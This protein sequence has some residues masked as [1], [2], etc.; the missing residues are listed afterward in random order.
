MLL[1]KDFLVLTKKCFGMQLGSSLDEIVM[2]LSLFTQN[3]KSP[4]KLTIKLKS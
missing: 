2:I 1:P 4:T 3:S